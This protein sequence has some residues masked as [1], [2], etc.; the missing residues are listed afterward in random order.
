[1]N[2]S[3][4]RPAGWR[5]LQ[6]ER[7]GQRGWIRAGAVVPAMRCPME[8]RAGVMKSTVLFVLAACQC[9]FAQ[10]PNNP[11]P[12]GPPPDVFI[13][14]SIDGAG[15]GASVNV[16]KR[17]VAPVLGAPYSATITTESVQ[18]LGDGNRIVVRSTGFVARDSQG[19]TRQ[20]VELPA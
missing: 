9:A 18:T 14:R 11:P 7:V 1:G 10:A 12:P 3:A 13:Y 2:V 6:G 19:R 5:Q 4:R 16:V 17:E 8:G 15:G 20:Q